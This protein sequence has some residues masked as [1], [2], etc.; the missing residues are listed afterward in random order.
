[1]MY[2]LGT[3]EDTVRDSTTKK[4]VFWFAHNEENGGTKGA[5]DAAEAVVMVL[6][7]VEQH[8]KKSAVEALYA[9]R[10]RLKRHISTLCALLNGVAVNAVL[11]ETLKAVRDTI[12]KE[13]GE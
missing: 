3:F 10:L 7:A 12:K 13:I 2:E 5:H 11:D 6:N 9:D 4:V 8:G 1:M